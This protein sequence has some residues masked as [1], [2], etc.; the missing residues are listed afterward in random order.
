MGVILR[1]KN[2]INMENNRGVLR[3]NAQYELSKRE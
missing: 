1:K 3:A 2:K